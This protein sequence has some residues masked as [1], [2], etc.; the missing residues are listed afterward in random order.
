MTDIPQYRMWT[1]INCEHLVCHNSRIVDDR[2]DE[3]CYCTR[4]KKAIE[5][6]VGHIICTAFTMDHVHTQN[7]T[8]SEEPKVV[9]CEDCPHLRKQ[10]ETVIV[11]GLLEAETIYSCQKNWKNIIRNPGVK[12]ICSDREAE[13]RSYTVEF[14]AR[15]SVLVDATSRTDAIQKAWPLCDLEDADVASVEVSQ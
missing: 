8:G 1:C 11:N 13:T 4:R 7:E 15:Q 10:S 9:R 2:Y 3:T 5:N 12:R 6:P 14:V